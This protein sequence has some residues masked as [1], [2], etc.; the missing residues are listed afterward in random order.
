M[1]GGYDGRVPV[2]GLLILPQLTGLTGRS[3]IY[4]LY[5]ELEFIIHLEQ[6]EL[7]WADHKDLEEATPAAGSIRW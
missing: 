4:I 2:V 3:T 6:L 7:I 5:F 1:T